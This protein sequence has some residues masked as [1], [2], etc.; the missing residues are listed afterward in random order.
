MPLQ[1]L[2][3]GPFVHARVTGSAAHS[4]WVRM[5]EDLTP[6]RRLVLLADVRAGDTL[7]TS[8]EA[9]RQA[10]LATDWLAVAIVAR[11]GAQYGVAR[12][13]AAIAEGRGTPVRVFTDVDQARKWLSRLAPD[14]R[15]RRT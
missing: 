13:T 6:A 3:G 2:K 10:V 8:D 14:E 5:N 4:D 9:R 7:P 11:P 12:V 1:I 15:R